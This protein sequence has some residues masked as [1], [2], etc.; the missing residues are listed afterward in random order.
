MR[1]WNVPG[2]MD[3]CQLCI[4]TLAGFYQGN[5][6]SWRKIIMRVNVTAFMLLI[7][8][9]QLS[10]TS[11]SQT[12]SLNAT[13]QPL[14]K[15]F[16]EIEEQTG[17]YIMYNSR[18]L[19]STSP[20]TI[21]AT[22]MPLTDFL[23]TV[24]GRLSLNYTINEKTI[25]V[26][27]SPVNEPYIRKMPKT[28]SQQ[29]EITGKIT[30]RQGEPLEGVTVSV[31]NTSVVTTTNGGGIYQILLPPDSKILAFSIVGY[32]AQEINIGSSSMIN[33]VLVES[34]SDLEEVVVVG[35]GTQRRADLTT[36]VASLSAE[37]IKNRPVQNFGEAI[38]G[39]MPGVQ[40][41]Q[42][43]G[44]PG[45]EGLAIRVRGVG[46]ITQSNTPL[47][48]VDGYPMEGNALR[49]LNMSDIE[50]IQVLKD[51]SS[52]AIYGSRGANGVVIINTK[53]GKAGPPVIR[54][55]SHVGVQQRGK[56]IGMM[57]RDEYV[58][59]FI[60]GRNQAWLD[61]PINSADPN[62][63][64]HTINDPNSR[65][66]LYP[67]AGG[68]YMIPDGQNGYMYNFMDPASVAS[69]PDNNWQDLLYR[70][71]LI[72][73]NELSVS[74]GSDHTQYNFSGG[75]I[76][77]EGIV[78]NT[79]YDRFN[80]RSNI[81]SQLN[82]KFA[83]GVNL[84][85]FSSKGKEQA[86]GKDAPVMYALNL[87]PIYPLKNEDG[88]YGSMVRNPE[89][90]AG[91]VANP[92][93]IAEQVLNR[94]M[95]YGWLGTLSAEWQVLDHLD[96]KV[97][98]NGGIQ[99]SE[100]KIYEASYIDFD[101]SKAPR[102]ARGQNSRDTDVDWVIENTLNYSNTFDDKHRFT[103]L[104]GYTVQKNSD[105]S[106]SGEARGFANDDITTLNAGTMYQLT[107][108]ESASSMISY[109]GRINYAYDDRYL[110]TVA[111]RTDG[112]SRFGSNR[113]WGTF[114]S[115]SVGW[116]ISEEQFLKDVRV[117][118]DLRLRASFGISGNNRIGN[119]SSIGLL[120]S[121]FY[122]I[123]ESLVNT[124]G[125]NT[126]PNDDLSWEKTQQ[127][128]VGLDFGLFN[129]R[130]R[131]ESDFYYSESVDLLLNV[132]VPIITG[133]ASQIQNIGKVANKGMEFLIS[134][135]NLV[136]EFQWNTNF[137]ISFNR[138]EVL[139]LGPEARPIFGSAPNANN[140]F[141]TMVGKPIASFWGY[142]YDGVFLS[143][144]E[145]DQYPHLNADKVGDGRYV[146]VNG[147][148]VLNQNDKTIIGDNHPLFTA[149]LN[150]TFSYKNFSLSIQLT[151]SQGA[152]VFSFYKRMV[153]I[154]HGDR[155][156]IIEQND[157]WR[158]E[159][160]PGDGTH[161]RPT[162][163]PSG[164]QRDP[165]SAWV[166]DASYLRLRNLNFSYDLPNTFVNRLG[167]KGMSAYVTGSNLFT[168]T[169]YA[170]YDPETSSQGDGLSKGGDYLGYP[171]ARV[172][173]LGVNLS[174]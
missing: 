106:M 8:C 158:S 151:A 164:W 111:L 44:A 100:Q 35:Y 9:I 27:K 155:N 75:Y 170:G 144:S 91:D 131:F 105:R 81:H 94:R 174:I 138:N 169:K 20:V 15:V 24:L 42:I 71:A 84:M 52:T 1:P 90:L 30:N 78:L 124:V 126:M 72:N 167:L 87:P 68:Q 50:S 116:R 97:S 57:N 23:T 54:I 10:A 34:M 154:Y 58:Q 128:N 108:S 130:V 135:R 19:A 79:D 152:E 156:G 137:N 161:F 76:K 69:M 109:L 115:A 121:G 3:R 98:I 149:G 114:P 122:P 26:T 147:D 85:A 62:K 83:I 22:N 163:T 172:Y 136:N 16:E 37:N 80:F 6:L 33:V 45:G 70:N 60:D 17:Y 77:Q 96:Y 21:Q 95:R 32:D 103:G 40:V 160:N 162:R 18:I 112:S 148:G 64:P 118:N 55:N 140:S 117:I 73:Q 4:D 113:K 43:S 132:P 129:Q 119:Y 99:D 107:S 74:G 31:K 5:I 25:L 104:L 168:I 159:D 125:P 2:S 120:S 142:R 93:G 11:L 143:Q 127:F 102:P 171:T 92:I 145:L 65:R 47:Y 63:D 150:N 88:T 82:E 123:G 36:A 157:R 165:S 12:V 56:E 101:A 166:Q 110:L 153:G 173:I 41:Q 66:A 7:G 51:A 38:A 28:L 49:L 39:Q 133:Y 48:V 46:S 53:K 14:A 146:D 89:I 13:A 139:E 29:R 59:W 67:G 61:A 86:N 141:I 134:S